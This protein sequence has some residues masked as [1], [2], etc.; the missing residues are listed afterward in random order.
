MKAIIKKPGSGPDLIEIDNTLEALQEAVGGYIET[1]T[2]ARDTVIICNEEG[3]LLGYPPNVRFLGVDFVGTI[4]ICGVKRDLFCDVPH[5]DAWLEEL[6][7][8]ENLL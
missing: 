6:D 1:V 7:K 4:L 8:K 2:I 5:P 3:R